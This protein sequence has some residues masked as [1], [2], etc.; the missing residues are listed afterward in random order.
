MNKLVKETQTVTASVNAANI[1][2]VKTKKRV[3]LQPFVVQCP[4][5]GTRAII[6]AKKAGIFRRGNCKKCQA[7]RN[8]KFVGK[9][10][11]FGHNARFFKIE[12]LL[13]PFAHFWA[14]LE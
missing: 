13:S 9:V 8:L 10:K 14:N 5:C 6:D 4:D 7:Q 1:H 12:W 3:I 11:R 2:G